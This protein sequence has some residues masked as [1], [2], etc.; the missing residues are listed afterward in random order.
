MFLLFTFR[1]VSRR[2]ADLRQKSSR[3]N[4]GQSSVTVVVILVVVV[5]LVTNRGHARPGG[6]PTTSWWDL[7]LPRTNNVKYILSV[8]RE[9]LP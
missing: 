1:F 6:N 9:D 7:K 5:V 3:W 2:D 4:S 8:S